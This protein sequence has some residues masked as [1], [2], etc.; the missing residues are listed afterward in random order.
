M[1]VGPPA[2]G[3]ILVQRLDAV[4]GTTMS[5]Q[6]N[7]VSGA[8]P[9]AVAQPGEAARPGASQTATR[10]P[11]QAVQAGGERGAR[12]GAAGVDAKTAAA[13]ALAARG[14][15]TSTGT[16]ASAPTTLGQTAR[17]I[18]ALLAQYPGQAPAVSARAPL[19]TPPAQDGASPPAGGQPA[20]AA[21]NAPAQASAGAGGAASTPSRPE[22]AQA[23]AAGAR[24]PAQPPPATLAALAGRAV[25]PAAPALA[26]ALRQTLQASGLFYESHL[27]DLAFGKR[28]VQ[29]LQAEPQARLPAAGAEPAATPRAPE[30]AT[31]ARALPAAEAAPP[32]Q[33][34]TH[35]PGAPVPG[36]HQDATLLVRQQLDVLANQMLAWQGQAWP[37]A[38]MEWEVAREHG[39]DAAGQPGTHWATR[40]KLNLPRL[41]T[42]EARLNLAANQL[43]LHVVA[44]D[45]AAE[46]GAAA[47]ALRQQLSAAGLT[48]TNLSVDAIGAPGF[49]L[50][51]A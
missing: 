13:L 25:L 40:L 33:P 5:A 26:Q 36:I 49:D 29:Q 15:Q 19:W 17:T 38:P 1:S 41:G 37:G 34:A 8:R 42:V 6:S 12:Q 14:L 21:P 2:L 32:G 47:D 11:R 16:T 31:P 44:P 22:A 7:L 24:P 39:D 4:L 27:S 46:I 30:N 28:S 23:G 20:A 43:V 18:L 10:D 3:S 9:D 50:P 45:S 35:T 51:E 48:L